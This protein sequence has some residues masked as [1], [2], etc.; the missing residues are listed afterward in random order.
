[1]S[2]R[3]HPIVLVT[4]VAILFALLTL[5]SSGTFLTRDAGV[6]GSGSGGVAAASTSLTCNPTSNHSPSAIY[7]PLK[8]PSTNLSAG[9]RITEVMEWAVVNYTSADHG[10]SVHFPSIFF[11]FPLAPSGLFSPSLSP[12]IR[13]ITGPGWTNGAY[14]NRSSLIPA[15]L[16]FPTGGLARLSTE[17]LAIQANAAY[18]NLTLEFRWMWNVTQPNGTMAKS[19]WTMPKSTYGGGVTLPSI[20]YPAQYI[21]FVS[22]PAQG[23]SIQIG[24]NYTAQLGGPVAGRYYFLE[25]ENSVGH[26]VKSH[27]NTLAA[28]AT[29]GNVTIPII[30]YDKYLPP[31]KYLVHI[32]DVCG[33]IL[34]NKQVTAVYAP[35]ATV[36]FYVQPSLCGSLTFNGTAFANNTSGSF[37]PSSTPYVF[38]IPHCIGHTVKSES[39]TG[40]LHI[41]SPS[42]LLLSN[43]GTFTIQYN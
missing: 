4:L 33:A 43:N 42:H 36:T 23:A 5:S 17:K 10:I 16:S 25:L 1:M 30:N 37:P 18:G 6:A 38:T 41:T 28:N 15:G 13:N 39:D 3:A 2:A 24:T 27:A 22:G 32:H 12:Q 9:G 40:Y 31:G 26:V 14:T 21:T 11:S 7:L 20:F 8:E 35:S 19:F 29:T 34:Y